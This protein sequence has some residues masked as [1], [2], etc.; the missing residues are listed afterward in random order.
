MLTEVRN[1][2]DEIKLRKMEMAWQIAMKAMDADLEVN[3]SVAHGSER[4]LKLF[5]E[6]LTKAHEIVEQV[7]K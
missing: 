6:H 1:V 3:A 2:A 5:S 4:Y 7:F